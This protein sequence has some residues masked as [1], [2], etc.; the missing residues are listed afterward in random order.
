MVEVIAGKDRGK[1]GKV[2]RLVLDKDRL[3]VDGVNL[4]K[5]HQRRRPPAMQG[6][7]ITMPAPL[8]SANVMLVCPKCDRPARVGYRL[9]DDGKKSRVC[10]RCDELID[11]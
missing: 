10:K 8:S 7:I 5:R 1:R 9:L 2:L 3:V 6:G 4:V 11:Q